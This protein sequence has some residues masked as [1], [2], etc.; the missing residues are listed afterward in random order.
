MSEKSLVVADFL[1]EPM[2]LGEVFASSGL[3][4]DIKTASQAVVK[5][6]AG[7][8]LGL[9]PFQSMASIYMVSDKLS[10]TSNAMS[11]L[12]KKSK[13][14]DYSVVKLDETNCEIDFFENVGD[15]KKILGRSVFNLK[16]AARCGLVNK[17]TFKAYPKNML[18]ARALTNGARFYCPDA[19]CG[20]YVVEEMDDSVINVEKLDTPKSIV[21]IDVDKEASI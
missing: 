6:M 21:S 16:D 10:L 15:E 1:Q 9:T 5:I 13:R 2:A 20:Y 7:K 11:S 14:Y 8:E 17:D 18:F 4:K 12:I 19:M 3:F